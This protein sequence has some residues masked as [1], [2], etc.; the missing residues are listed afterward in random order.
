[1]L[2]NMDIAIFRFFNSAAHFPLLDRAMPYITEIGSGEMIFAV[3]VV[4]LLF[5]GKKKNVLCGIVLMAGSTFAYNTGHILKGVIQRP[6]PFMVLTDVELLIK[7]GGFSCP[8]NHST[9]AF[10]AAAVLSRYFGK[11]YIF[12]TLAAIVGIS[13]IYL[14]V[15]Y[16]SDVVFGALLGTAIGTLLARLAE[17]AAGGLER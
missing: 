14:G 10:T 17:K 12:F 11:A 3:A 9:M 4:M 15:H 7:A 5:V 16:P 6:R 13:R 8:S 2:Q 1:M